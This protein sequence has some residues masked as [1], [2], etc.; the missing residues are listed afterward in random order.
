LATEN[1]TGRLETEY[2]TFNDCVVGRNVIGNEQGRISF[3][4]FV[5]KFPAKVDSLARG[6]INEV[7][8]YTDSRNNETATKDDVAIASKTKIDTN[9]PTMM[10][11]G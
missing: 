1:T 8:L 11:F 6:S 4:N 7:K 2:E 5:G 3:M 9:S 10:G